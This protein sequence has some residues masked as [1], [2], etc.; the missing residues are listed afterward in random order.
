MGMYH[1]HAFVFGMYTVTSKG[2]CVMFVMLYFPLCTCICV[3][4]VY[5]YQQGRMRDVCDAVFYTG[6]HMRVYKLPAS[7]GV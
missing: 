2:G 3:R 1:T 7:E 5:G 4:V 6:T